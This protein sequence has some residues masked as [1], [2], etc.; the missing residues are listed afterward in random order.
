M[1]VRI[2]GAASKNGERASFVL[3]K[4]CEHWKSEGGEYPLE[5][6]RLNTSGEGK[7]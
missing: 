7:K 6:D 2:V 4:R 1:H 5:C 3:F